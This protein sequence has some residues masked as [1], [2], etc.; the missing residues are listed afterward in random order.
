M[1][2]LF[3]RRLRKERDSRINVASSPIWNGAYIK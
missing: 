3:S 1:M 2:G